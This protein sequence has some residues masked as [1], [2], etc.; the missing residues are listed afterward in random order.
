VVRTEKVEV[1]AGTFNALLVR[2]ELQAEDEVK[3]TFHSWFVPGIGRIKL[4]TFSPPRLSTVY[5]A[6][7]IG[8]T[9]S[10]LGEGPLVAASAL[11]SSSERD[12]VVMEKFEEGG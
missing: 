5:L 3:F 9:G 12:T 10:P 6:R 11:F 7:A 8:L 2:M 4:S 1:P